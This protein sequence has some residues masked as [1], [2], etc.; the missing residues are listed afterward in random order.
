VHWRP[1]AS[2]S[3]RR[4][5]SCF[6]CAPPYNPHSHRLRGGSVQPGLSADIPPGL[7]QPLPERRINAVRW[8]APR[9]RYPRIQSS[10]AGRSSI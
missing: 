1:T 10:L 5:G 6:R 2:G 7:Q 8:A 4:R 3:R 9:A